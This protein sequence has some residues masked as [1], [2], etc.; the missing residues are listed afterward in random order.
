MTELN[1]NSRGRWVRMVNPSEIPDVISEHERTPGAVAV[2]WT[3]LH[4]D[5]GTG[6][7]TCPG[8]SSHVEVSSG[9][10]TGLKLDL[11]PF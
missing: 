1:R 10:V 11:T 9:G 3:Y 2:M 5:A 8:V 6:L 7:I 4:E